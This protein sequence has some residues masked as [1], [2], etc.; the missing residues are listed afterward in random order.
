MKNKEITDPFY[1]QIQRGIDI[2]EKKHDQF[3]TIFYLIRTGQIALTLLITIYSG[4]L[5]KNGADSVPPAAA[6]EAVAT[7]TQSEKLLPIDYVF[8]LGA[9]ATALTALETLFQVEAKKGAYKLALSEL[10]AIRTDYVFAHMKSGKEL[11]DPSFVDGLFERYKTAISH[12]VT[13][14][15][16]DA[17]GGAKG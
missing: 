12:G 4:L 1:G 8:I 9:I 16:S 17:N 10:R 6:R 11:T 15:G 3:R 7:T 2:T 13:L 5:A 14:A